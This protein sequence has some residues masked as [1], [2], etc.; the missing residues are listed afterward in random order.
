[1]VTVLAMKEDWLDHHLWDTR[2]AICDN[3]CKRMPRT[4]AG[5]TVTS[6]GP[7]CT[8]FFDRENLI[9][10]TKFCSHESRVRK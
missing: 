3:S 6:I 2:A 9:C 1:M 7:K 8:N 10:A 5:K 4:L